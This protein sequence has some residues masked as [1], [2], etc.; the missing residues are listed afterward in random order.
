MELVA[1]REGVS[2]SGRQAGRGHGGAADSHQRW[3][4]HE[5]AHASLARDR[6]DLCR[7][8]ERPSAGPHSRPPRQGRASSRTARPRPRSE[9]ISRIRRRAIRARWRSGIHEGRKRQV[10]RMFAVMG[11]RVERLTRDPH[12][13]CGPHEASPRASPAASPREKSAELKKLAKGTEHRTTKA[14]K[15]QGRR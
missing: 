7:R 11:H 12:R 13:A 14:A 8:G 15:E 1:R 10:R 6:K 5:A 4:V 3:R 9:A 2:V